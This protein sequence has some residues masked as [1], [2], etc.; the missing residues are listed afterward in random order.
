MRV[1]WIPHAA[2]STPQRARDFCHELALRHVVHVTDWVADFQ[3]PRDYLSSRYIRNFIYRRGTDGPITIHGIAR[4]SPAIFSRHLRQL[5]AALFKL[6]L[7]QIIRTTRIDVVVG[8]YVA[9]PP[10][11]PRLVFDVFDDNV[12]YAEIYGRSRE[13]AGEIAASERAYLQ[14]ADAVVAASSVLVER[15]RAG[16]YKGPL[17]CIPNGVRMDEFS[18]EAGEHV[19][20]RLGIS[21][22]VVGLIGNHDKS[23]ELDRVLEVARVLAD[24]SATFLIVGRGSALPRAARLARLRRLDNVRFVGFVPPQQIAAYF[25]AID[26]GLCPYSRNRAADAASPMRLLSHSAAGSTVVCTRLEEVRRMALPNVVLVDDSPE[27][28]ARGV[29]EALRHPRGRSPR[30]ADYDIRQLARRY[31][32][33]LTG[34]DGAG[35]TCKSNSPDGHTRF[36]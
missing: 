26:V 27:D 30:I 2:W 17:A 23:V 21:G 28:V 25:S 7:A 34:N 8:T 13:L 5:N 36:A 6:Q 12:G 31:E 10:R 14:R 20:T 24:T 9:P 22:P 15:L 1:L 32:Q 29:R 3:S 16:G 4:I 11:V 19:R 33:V 35:G 18:K